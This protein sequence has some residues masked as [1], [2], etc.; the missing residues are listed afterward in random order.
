M[1]EEK[2][3]F[4]DDEASI[5]MLLSTY[6]R[7]RGYKVSLAKDGLEALR[8][9]MVEPPDLVITDVNMPNINGLELTRRL[10]TNHKTSRIPIIML[11]AQTQDDDILAGYAQGADDYVP[12]PVDLAILAAK[13]ETFLRRAASAPGA[14]AEEGVAAPAREG[15]VIVFIRGKGGV[16]A[17]TLA[18]NTAL[19]LASRPGGAALVDL[20]LEFGN[21]AQALGLAPERSLADLAKISVRGT[22]NATFEQF[23]TSHPSSLRVVAAPPLPEQAELVGIPTVQHTIDRLRHQVDYV[24]VDAAATFSEITL[25][26]LDAAHVIC[27]VASPQD[28]AVS[29]AVNCVDVLKKLDVPED[30]VLVILNHAVPHGPDGSKVSGALK[31]TPD[32]EVPYSAEIEAAANAGQPLVVPDSA[33]GLKE[34][35]EALASKVE[36]RT[37]VPV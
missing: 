29:G 27:V 25:A 26:A 15:N 10:R 18:T 16:G 24:I 2:I 1:A 9:V 8:A 35:F 13:V 7:Q 21:A 5:R 17:T 36:S 31:R 23:V 34:V 3:L 6:L 30:R 4:V 37:P 28:A 22:D 11:S 20:N 19:A 32:M 14:P 12:K 33:T